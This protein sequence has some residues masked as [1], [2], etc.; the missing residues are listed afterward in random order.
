M[1][2]EVR[3]FTLCKE[4]P[5]TNIGEKNAYIA[6]WFGIEFLLSLIHM[7]R[8]SA[9]KHF[10]CNLCQ[11]GFSSTWYWRGTIFCEVYVLA[12][13]WSV[14][15]CTFSLRI[16][17]WKNIF[18]EIEGISIYMMQ[19]Y[20]SLCNILLGKY[21]CKLWAWSLNGLFLF[22]CVHPYFCWVLI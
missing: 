10:N 8:K 6:T 7:L 14:F 2:C 20:K 4:F 13:I 21:L 15:F 1:E 16:H 9:R 17:I 3:M 19:I 18:I 5:W 11:T 22:K 12:F